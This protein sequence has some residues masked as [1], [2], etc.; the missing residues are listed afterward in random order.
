MLYTSSHYS[1]SLPA[2]SS[3]WL[4]L[5]SRNFGGIESHVLQLAS[6]LTRQGLK[7]EVIFLDDYGKHALK[8]RLHQADIPF[9]CLRGS[10]YT[11]FSCAIRKKPALIHTHGYKAGLMG[12][13]TGLLT[14]LPVV[15]SFHAG[16]K[17]SG[18]LAFYH[19]LDRISSGLCQGIIAVSEPIKR[20]L[21][22]K[23][24]VINNFVTM[25][26]HR[27][28]Q[29]RQVA[30]VGRLSHEKG[31]DNFIRLA[32]FYPGH[33]F[34]LYGTGPMEARLKRIATNNVI[35][36][37]AK[38]DMTPIWPRIAL[39]IMPS[40]FEGMPMSALEAMSNGIPVI[41]YSVG[42]LDKLITTGN[43]WL[44]PPEHF[45]GLKNALSGYL[46]A[47]SRT[48]IQISRQARNTIITN[49][50]DEAVLPRLLDIYHESI[51]AKYSCKLQ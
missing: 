31:P 46:N 51:A 28:K 17:L 47:D 49:F 25:K 27:P 7:A 8:E 35:F 18:K 9:T 38:Q 44:I 32:R 6:A 13:L 21:P 40:R 5:D 33:T 11:L 19:F 37:G 39:L 2:G 12:R 26:K 43:G 20:T 22:A 29:G 16:E 1:N 48:R 3:I 41:A 42:S 50:S 23:A 4:L 15:S 45:E 36:H 24:Q 14:R 34:H 10:W 30:F